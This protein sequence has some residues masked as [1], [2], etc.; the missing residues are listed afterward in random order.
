M[1]TV[2]KDHK[3]RHRDTEVELIVDKLMEL[4]DQHS[5]LHGL[6][7]RETLV[8]ALINADEVGAIRTWYNEEDKLVGLLLYQVIYT[9]WSQETIVAEEL[10]LS[11]DKRYAGIQ[12]LAMKELE[13]IARGFE[14]RIIISGNLISVDKKVVEN[15]YEKQGYQHKH[16]IFMKRLK[17]E[18][19]EL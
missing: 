3:L 11:L 12:R 8:Q 2:I 9:W 14:S 10:I 13:R 19:D 16:S 17:G 5:V 18:Q 6:G 1:D 4:G 7:N 15:G